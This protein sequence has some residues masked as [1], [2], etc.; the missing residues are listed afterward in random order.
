M[1]DST[2]TD[3]QSST[4]TFIPGE[5]KIP[6][7]DEP[8][9]EYMSILTIVSGKLR[10]SNSERYSKVYASEIFK[11]EFCAANTCVALNIPYIFWKSKHLQ[12]QYMLQK[13]SHWQCNITKQKVKSNWKFVVK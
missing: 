10:P 12:V 3:M 6:V 9:V 4:Y 1:L 11:Y 2:T 7:F 13:K 5:E 8:L